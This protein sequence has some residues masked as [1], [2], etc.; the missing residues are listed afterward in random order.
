MGDAQA[1][2]TFR[3]TPLR[4]ALLAVLS[5]IPCP[6]LAQLAAPVIAEVRAAR[7]AQNAALAA[8]LF[9]SA[10]TFWTTD[11]V[12]TTSRGRV[13]RGKDAYRHAF[14]MD[15]V[16]VYV[17]TP[18]HIEAASPWL[19]V[20]EEGMWSGHIG[21]TGPA[22]IGGRYAAQ[23]HRVNGRWFIRSEVFVALTCS[24][25]PCRWPVESP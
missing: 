5:V 9:D 3:L 8:H 2:E 12:I 18:A 22:V 13:L 16:M 24:G 15:S 6:V 4:L 23:W 11:V 19:L 17:R 1:N 7:L 21:S 10:A 14:A 25:D 20:W